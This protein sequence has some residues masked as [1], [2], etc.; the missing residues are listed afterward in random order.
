MSQDKNK[1][2]VCIIS[3]IQNP[4]VNRW[5]G[6]LL[7]KEYDVIVISSETNLSQITGP[8]II[9]CLAMNYKSY[10]RN[11]L[12]HMN[13]TIRIRRILR[14]VKPD[15]VHIHSLDYV[16]PLMVGLVDLVLGGFPGLI[17]S[18][19]GTDIIGSENSTPT[20]RGV[21]AKNLLLRRAKEIT[22]TSRFLADA[23]AK[24]APKGKK[25]H[26]VPFGIDCEQFS[27]KKTDKVSRN[28]RIGYIKHLVPKYGPD[29]LLKAMAIVLDHFPDTELVIVGHGTMEDDLKMLAGSLGITG[30]VKFTGYLQSEEIPSILESIDIFIMPSLMDAFGVAAIEAQAMEVPVVASNVG[31]VSEAVIDGKTGFLVE[32]KNV[33]QL[34]TA[35]IKL[36]KDPELRKNMGKEGRRFVLENYNLEENVCL[37]E[38]LYQNLSYH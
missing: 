18:T 21:L 14:R 28:I 5:A 37:F 32:P 2:K 27:K 15:V 25:I 33:Q 16:H 29:Y 38:R 31:G 26:I 20:R 23:T 11:M 10:I 17:V 3:T 19:W 12:H 4:H 1:I 34:A 13:R 30:N 24:L 22:A 7:S 35:V 6:I 8:E 9:E 36:I